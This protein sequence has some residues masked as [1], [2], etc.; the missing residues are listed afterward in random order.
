MFFLLIQLRIFGSHY[1]QHVIK[2]FYAQKRL[3]SYGASV[4]NL[5]ISNEIS[6]EAAKES[7]VLKSLETKMKQIDSKRAAVAV[8]A[9]KQTENPKFYLDGR[10]SGD[11][12]MFATEEPMKTSDPDELL[13][14]EG[15][16]E[17]VKETVPST[18]DEKTELNAGKAS[19]V[20]NAA[21]WC[22][23][24]FTI[25]VTFVTLRFNSWAINHR[26]VAS[27]LAEKK[28][29][30]KLDMEVAPSV[31]V[32]SP[33]CLAPATFV[34]TDHHLTAAVED[35]IGLDD[36]VAHLDRHHTLLGRFLISCWYLLVSRT[37]L[38][39]YVAVILNM[40]GNASVL[41]LPL[42]LMAFFWGSLCIPRPSKTFW[43]SC[44]TYTEAVVVVKFVCQ[45]GFVSFNIGKE[46]GIIEKPFF[47]PR[48][49][50][51]LKQDYFAA[52]DIL[53][54]MALFYH[55]YTLK[56]YCPH[57]QTLFIRIDTN[58]YRHSDCGKMFRVRESP[59]HFR[60][61]CHW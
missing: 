10:Y 32:S 22:L 15:K 29:Q 7:M 33:S 2:E 3:A 18:I 59:I 42:P 21:R 30:L 55:R 12:Y 43:L 38:L 9:G 5:L 23:N 54:L 19:V 13:I 60:M 26:R 48:I 58:Y 24:A 28:K 8:A 17:L 61:K 49:L 37:E 27:L 16:E 4:I 47:I 40:I 36:N 1:F 57:Q 56:V 44:I 14:D 39:C 46:A 41:A 11:Y 53:L 50:G 25:F 34:N 35:L 6:A 51:I 52:W 20:G 31:D 45:F